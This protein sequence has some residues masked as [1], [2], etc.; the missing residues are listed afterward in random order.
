MS[1]AVT[2]AFVRHLLTFGGGI[3][4]ARGV[5]DTA[6]MEAIIG[7]VVTIAGAVWSVA[8]KKARA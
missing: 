7:A 1:A 5:L 3:L 8:D 6:T 4:V 2:L